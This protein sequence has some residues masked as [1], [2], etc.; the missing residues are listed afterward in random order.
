MG[1]FKN[2]DVTIFHEFHIDPWLVILGLSVFRW[3]LAWLSVG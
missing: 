2:D 3:Y 1:R